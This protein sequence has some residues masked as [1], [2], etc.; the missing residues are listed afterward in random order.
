VVTGKA[1]A[2]D[3]GVPAVLVVSVMQGSTPSSRT[4]C[5]RAARPDVR[6]RPYGQARGSTAHRVLVMHG[7]FAGLI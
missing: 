4:P 7:P 1:G 5:Q 2:V 6:R 3:S